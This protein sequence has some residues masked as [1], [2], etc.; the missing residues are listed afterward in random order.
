ML[1]R[2]FVVF[3]NQNRLGINFSSLIGE[4]LVKTGNFKSYDVVAM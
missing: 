2:L 4:I 3:V 1:Y